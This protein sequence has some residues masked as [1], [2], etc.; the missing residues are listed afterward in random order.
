VSGAA[1]AVA[2]AAALAV[3][4]GAAFLMTRAP[5]EAA[6]ATRLS[7]SAPGVI[8]PQTSVAVSPDG[9]RVAF[10]ATDASGR[11]LLWIRELASLQPRSLPGT[12]DAA[13]PFW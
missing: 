4:A 10:V 11:S 8:T 2:A 3:G 7:L 13:H 5:R 9:G 1:W 6:T 12:E